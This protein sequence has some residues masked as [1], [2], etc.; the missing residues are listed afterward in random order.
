MNEKTSTEADLG[1]SSAGMRDVVIRKALVTGGSRGIGRGIARVL[2]AEGCDVAI[3]YASQ[4]EQAEAVA[5]EIRARFGRTC[6]V[7]QASLEQE[8]VPGATVQTAFR[9]LGGLDVLVNNA[10]ITRFSDEIDEDVEKLNAV[11]NLDF[12]AYMLASA[13]AARLM[14][15][16]G[17]R[18]AIVNITSSRAERAYP[19]DAL[20]GAVKAAVKRATESLALKYAPHG[21][22]VNC[23][24]PGATVAPEV[25]QAHP[26]FA[27]LASRIPLGRL[28]TPEDVGQA[29]AWL[30]SDKASY[31]TGIT[32]RVDGGL[33]LPGMP[34][35]DPSGMAPGWGA[36]ARQ[37]DNPAT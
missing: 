16:H 12:K 34:E 13:A 29:V 9:E 17:V 26:H 7:I 14:V 25:Q 32:L 21:I 20:Y 24:A 18:G 15:D 3:T 2:A 37:Q 11:I 35:H 6:A 31:V 10:G 23:V 8:E 33:I 5:E 36:R 22:R 19:N 30:V 1:T 4:R 27:R 28:G